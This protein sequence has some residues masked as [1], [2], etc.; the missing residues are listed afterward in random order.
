VFEISSHFEIGTYESDDKPGD[1][2]V[3]VEVHTEE[4]PDHDLIMSYAEAHE[5]FWVLA[6]FF[7]R[8][9]LNLTTISH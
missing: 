4:D 3:L 8:S 6:G 9:Q 1:E 2:G 7:A 5:L